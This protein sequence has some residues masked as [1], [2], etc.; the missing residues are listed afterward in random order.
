MRPTL[1][2]SQR[3]RRSRVL[4]IRALQGLALLAALTMLSGFR[5][6]L[7]NDVATD[8]AD[9][10]AFLPSAGIGPV[11]KAFIPQI[12]AGYPSLTTLP[13]PSTPLPAAA[14]AAARAAARMPRWS[15]TVADAERVEGVAT[16]LLLRFK[17]DFTFRLRPRPGSGALIDGRSRSRVGK[18]DFGANAAR[19]EA[20]FK[21]VEEEV[22]A[23][24]GGD[25]RL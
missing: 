21:L 5:A 11:P 20:F 1:P 25:A 22:K 15:V 24:G 2:S 12:R 17:D 19:I 13:L 18:G 4:R 16:T 14:A 6:P 3:R 10:P 9:P 7:I 8:L 23:G